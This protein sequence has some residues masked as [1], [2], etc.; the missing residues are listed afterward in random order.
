MSLFPG[1]CVVHAST[2]SGQT[3]DVLN[4]LCPCLPDAPA[5]AARIVRASREIPDEG[6]RSLGARRRTAL[7]PPRC[8]P[9][10]A[11]KDL[12]QE[13][14]KFRATLPRICSRSTGRLSYGPIL[15]RRAF[16]QWFQRN[17]ETEPPQPPHSPRSVT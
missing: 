9:F 10:A 5:S 1:G 4:S 13:A 12:H 7:P 17:S 11:P 14:S 6:R 2:G 16:F 8:P 3:P 15:K